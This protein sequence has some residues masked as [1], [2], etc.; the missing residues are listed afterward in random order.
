[1]EIDFF[2]AETLPEI[3]ADDAVLLRLILHD[4]DDAL[5]I[6]ILKVWRRA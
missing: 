6:T 1:M 4:W 2:K 5:S 3:G